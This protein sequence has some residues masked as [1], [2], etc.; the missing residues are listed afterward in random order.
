MTSLRGTRV[1]T[2]HLTKIYSLLPYQ[3]VLFL[4]TYRTPIT[5]IRTGIPRGVKGSLLWFKNGFPQY[6][7][8]WYTRPPGLLW[9]SLLLKVFI[10]VLAY[11]LPFQGETRRY[12]RCFRENQPLFFQQ[13][14][15]IL[16]SQLESPILCPKNPCNL[17]I[18]P[19]RTFINQKNVFHFKSKYNILLI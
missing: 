14:F 10:P 18:G 1:Q 4:W 12:T 7:F 19:L 5:N 17:L 2:G 3:N 8:T 6:L 13:L 9:V 15:Y 16:L 11:R